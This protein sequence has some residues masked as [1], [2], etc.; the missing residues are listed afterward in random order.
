[1]ILFRV[2]CCSSAV[3][4]ALS[5]GVT[6]SDAIDFLFDAQINLYFA[7]NFAALQ[8][9]TNSTVSQ[10]S[11]L[12][13]LSRTEACSKLFPMENAYM[14]RVITKEMTEIKHVL[15]SHGVT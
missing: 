6:A 12:V 11:L 2:S 15:L 4:R 10:C 8:L 7:F 1:V 14:Y 3:R 13:C 9:T 5:A